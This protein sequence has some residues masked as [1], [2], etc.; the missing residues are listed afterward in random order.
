[1]KYAIVNFG[2]NASFCVP[3][4]DLSAFLATIAT[5]P[6]VDNTWRDNRL[7]HY[8][9]PSSQP[10]IRLID[11]MPISNEEFLALVAADEA[12]KEEAVA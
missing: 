11:E 1:M 10:E 4:K 9:N 7:V 2:Y 8:I 5:C 3:V 6:R 12:R